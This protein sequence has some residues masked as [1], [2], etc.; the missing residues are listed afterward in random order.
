[1]RLTLATVRLLARCNGFQVEAGGELVGHVATP[2]FSGT[3]LRPEFLIVRTVERIPG[4][5]RL[6][7]PDAVVAVDSGERIVHLRLAPQEL[8]ELEEG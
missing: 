8:A 2:V 3:S 1:M 7:P 4:R 5:F 6:V